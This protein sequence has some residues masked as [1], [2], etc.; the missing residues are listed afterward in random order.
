MTYWEKNDSGK[1]G[2]PLR[3]R[4]QC[5]RKFGE[6]QARST[7]KQEERKRNDESMGTKD[8]KKRTG[9]ESDAMERIED[10][11]GDVPGEDGIGRM[12]TDQ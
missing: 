8:G 4:T 6:A 5:W 11:Y 9:R 12:N 1:F 10:E 3:G 7:V 2:P